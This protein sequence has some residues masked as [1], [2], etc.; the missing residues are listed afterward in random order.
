MITNRMYYISLFNCFLYYK[1][2]NCFTGAKFELNP[3]NTQS[4][5]TLA[6][7]I[8]KIEDILCTANTWSRREP[9]LIAIFTFT[10]ATLIITIINCYKQWKMVS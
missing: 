3:N 9:W 7:C 10:L 8:S 6:N 1:F 5:Q 4:N 2:Y